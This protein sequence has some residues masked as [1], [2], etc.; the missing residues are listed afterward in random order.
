MSFYIV[1]GDILERNVDAI[2][3]AI[4]PHLRL[5]E[6]YLQSK[7]KKICGAKLRYEM[8]Q[9][10]NINISECV[11]VNAYNLPCKK[12]IFAASPKEVDGKDEQD[13]LENTYINCLD[14][15]VAFELK[16]INFCLL[17]AGA[18]EMNKR[19]AIEIAIDTITN[20][21]KD[22]DLNVG[23]VIYEKDTF[24][25]YRSLFKGYE[26]KPG[27]FS[28][29]ETLE[30]V[31]EERFIEQRRFCWYQKRTVEILENGPETKLFK[32]KL[33]YFMTQKGLSKLDCYNGIISKTMFNNYLKGSVPRK[34]TVV[35]LGVNMGLDRWEID[36]LLR[37]IRESLDDMINA[38]QIIINGLDDY[39]DVEMINKDLVLMGEDPL[40]TNKS[41]E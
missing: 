37:T 9:L 36:E 20:Y 3:V 5:D 41:A 19:K 31:L 22:K 18:Y 25:N 30:K 28:D 23:L 33:E 13:N 4:A 7:I 24:Y 12:I 35:A 39:K 40:P 6:G 38:D 14:L 29:K 21:I 17:S 16:S 8:E 2:V 32:E 10:K 11:I 34:Y 1:K 26:I 27:T 15:A